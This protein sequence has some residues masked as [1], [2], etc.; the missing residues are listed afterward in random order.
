MYFVS[1]PERRL[2]TYVP[3]G[4]GKSIHKPW[5][6]VCQHVANC[7]HFWR[8]ILSLFST[9]A[10]VIS[11]LGVP[12]TAWN[13]SFTNCWNVINILDISSSS[14]CNWQIH[15]RHFNLKTFLE[16]LT[17]TSLHAVH[18]DHSFTFPKSLITVRH[19]LLD[20]DYSRTF[21]CSR[22]RRTSSLIHP[23]TDNDNP[24]HWNS[25]PRDTLICR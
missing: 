1:K 4:H 3:N 7:C 19:L 25:F 9:R 14:H 16:Q 2:W 12:D 18:I 23:T 10:I 17:A 15:N 20:I 11:L 5:T 8:Y 24:L 13:S 22:R 21:D 6:Q